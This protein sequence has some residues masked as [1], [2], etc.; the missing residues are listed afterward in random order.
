MRHLIA[1]LLVCVAPAVGAFAD[2]ETDKWI[3]E[4]LTLREQGKDAEALALFEKANAKA[5]SPRG[6]A[7]VALAEQAMGRFVVAQ[8]HLSAAL[9]QSSDAWITSRKAALTSALAAIEKKLARLT[10]TSNAEGARLKVNGQDAG[11]LPLAAPLVLLPGKVKIE[12]SAP[13]YQTTTK[14]LD[15]AAEAKQTEAV[16][17]AKPKPVA[18]AEPAKVEPTKEPEPAKEP[19][20]EAAV[21][22][23]AEPAPPQP[24]VVAPALDPGMSSDTKAEL[25]KWGWISAAVAGG[26]LTLGVILVAVSGPSENDILEGRFNDSCVFTEDGGVSCGGPAKTLGIISLVTAALTGATATGL[27]IAGYSGDGPQAMLDFTP[28]GAFVRVTF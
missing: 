2:A 9:A 6:L 13:G 16:S 15:L 28:T 7:Q 10:V 25:S 14:T 24:A 26:T 12:V 27:L 8:K 1:A 19:P 18:S 21:P 22:P 20:V 4:G 17:L 5:P 11:K 3:E 23:P